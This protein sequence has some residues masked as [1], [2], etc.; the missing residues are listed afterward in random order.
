MAQLA[1]SKAGS[2]VPRGVLLAALVAMAI[3]VALAWR[4]RG[5]ND[6][7]AF[8]VFLQE[9][10]GSG[11]RV[12]Y[13][14]DPTFNH[15]PFVLYLLSAIGWLR[16]VTGLSPWFLVRLPSIL[17]DLGSVWLVAKLLGPRL[18]DPSTR[19]GL[20]LV[21]AAPASILISGF[22]GNTDPV[23]IFFLLLSIY[24][25]EKRDM[26][27]LA[28]V[29]MGMATNIKIVPLAFW[30]AIFL[31][32]PSW[33]R[34]GEYFGAAVAAIVVASTLL[35]FEDPAL[36]ARKVLGYPSAYGVWGVSEI[37]SSIP[38]LDSISAAFRSEGRPILVVT[39]L[40]LSVWMNLRRPA[41]E[42]FRQIGVLAF[43][44]LAI[45]P[46]F[47]VQ[48]LAWLVPW[49]AGLGVGLG[50][51]AAAAWCVLSGAFLVIVYTYW[52]QGVAT[53]EANPDWL[54]SGFWSRGIPLDVADSN[55]MHAWWGRIVPVAMICWISVVF[56][57]VVEMRAVARE[58]RGALA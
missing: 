10:R 37:L 31:W 24:L 34:R 33:R 28:G 6:I 38:A 43:A 57:L 3:K 22:H 47:G 20:F 41:P 40:A 15:P 18:T 50:A 11:A 23:M 53:E 12:L 55:T 54:T 17:A 45:S 44:F 36:L 52:C 42:L 4:T 32:L 9:Y 21:A 7:P 39:L 27:L 16:T 48:Y 25:L 35:I 30:P 58:R 2:R 46:G 26:V 49:I 14:Q 19:F 8:W 1:H 13:E 29:A 51:W 56:V 5:T